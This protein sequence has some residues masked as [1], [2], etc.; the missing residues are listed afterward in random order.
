MEK[1]TSRRLTNKINIDRR[2]TEKQ[3]K[4]KQQLKQNEIKKTTKIQ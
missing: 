1:K 3:I 4:Q 2:K